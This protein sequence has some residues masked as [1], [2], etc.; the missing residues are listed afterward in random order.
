MGESGSITQD[1]I[2][3]LEYLDELCSYALSIGMTYNEY[4]YEP[5]DKIN[6]YVRAEQMRQR[7]KNNELWLQGLYVHIA[8]GDLVPVLNPFSKDHKARPYLDKPIAI[9]QEEQEEQDKAKYDRFVKYMM[10][11]VK[12]SEVG[13]K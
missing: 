9:T 11:K 4:W 5:Y 3:P 1:T 10:S 7:K 6:L 13:E 2:S 8:I 12:K